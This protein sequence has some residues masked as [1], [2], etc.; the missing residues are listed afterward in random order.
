MTIV[1]VNNYKI[2]YIRT[3]VVVLVIENPPETKNFSVSPFGPRNKRIDSVKIEHNR[4]KN[5][6]LPPRE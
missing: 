4:F 1:I 3:V 6:K 5:I 2:Q